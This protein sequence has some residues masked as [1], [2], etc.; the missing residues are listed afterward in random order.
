MSGPRP[1]SLLGSLFELL[2]LVSIAIAIVL[3]IIGSFNVGGVFVDSISDAEALLFVAIAAT[4]Q[5]IYLNR[6]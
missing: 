2:A 1:S 6:K 4:L 5:A 3:L